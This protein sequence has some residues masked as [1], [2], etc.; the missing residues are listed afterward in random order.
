MHIVHISYCRRTGLP[1]HVS[2]TVGVRAETIVRAQKSPR[3][4]PKVREPFSN[5]T[6][7][8]LA[9][10]ISMLGHKGAYF[11]G[12]TDLDGSVLRVCLTLLEGAA[13]FLRKRPVITCA[14][15]EVERHQQREDLERGFDL[16]TGALADMEVIF[17]LHWNGIVIHWLLHQLEEVIHFGDF[18]AVHMLVIERYHVKIKAMMD[19]GTVNPMRT[20]TTKMTAYQDAEVWRL[21]QWAK[22]GKLRNKRLSSIASNVAAAIVEPKTE[23]STVGKGVWV[24]LPPRQFKL[25]LETWAREIGPGFDV[26]ILDKFKA[27]IRQPA[28]KRR[29]TASGAYQV[30][31][32]WTAGKWKEWFSLALEQRGVGARW[33]PWQR[34]FAEIT[35]HVQ[36][37]R[38]A[39][40]GSAMFC[41]VGH[42]NKRKFDNST[43]EQLFE[44]ENGRQESCFGRIQD[45]FTH[46]MPWSNE[47]GKELSGFSQRVVL[48]ADWYV[49]VD[50]FFPPCRSGLQQVVF[51]E[52]WSNT[53]RMG[54]LI[55][56]YAHNISLW[57]TNGIAGDGERNTV[58]NVIR[59]HYFDSEE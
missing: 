27:F 12:L 36:V 55:N 10:A 46:A 58:F 9:E 4:Y 13:V 37:F 6:S 42:S 32:W 2:E 41:T 31:E 59:Y 57:P 47:P 11:L 8:K 7:G 28:Q 20:L 15:P 40:V 30:V 26:Q 50:P 14:E 51:D 16:L 45:L 19:G 5:P 48:E 53:S 33:A 18:E 3:G 44:H 29:R 17:P 35:D 21:M 25:L 23:A 56:M 52:H 54:F 49:P 22:G 43:I 34:R 24:I 39:T 1:F 38:M